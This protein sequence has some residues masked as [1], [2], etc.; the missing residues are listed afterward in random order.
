M[1]VTTY[2]IQNLSTVDPVIVQ[3]IDFDTQSGVQHTAN[4]SGLGGGATTAETRNSSQERQNKTY[5]T[6]SLLR[7]SILAYTHPVSPYYV[8]HTGT[9]LVV[10]STTGIE[11]GWTADDNYYTGT[12][13]VNVLPGNTLLMS[14]GPSNTPSNLR[15]ITFTPTV[16]RITVEDTT[17]VK[18]GWEISGNGYSSGQ[19]VVTVISP[20]QLYVSDQPDTTPALGYGNYISFSTSPYFLKLDSVGRLEVGFSA[21][22]SNNNWDGSQYITDIDPGEKTV[23]MS[24]QPNGYPNTGDTIKFVSNTTLG[25]IQPLQSAT[26][27]MDY[28]RTS[29]GVARYKGSA[30]IFAIQ[31]TSVEKSIGNF[32]DIALA[33]PPPDENPD[34]PYYSPNQ[35]GGRGNGGE[36]APA[37]C[38]TGTPS[39]GD[40]NMCR[41][42]NSSPGGDCFVKGTLVTLYDGSQIAIENLKIGD[43]IKGLNGI[44]AVKKVNI[45]L[46][47]QPGKRDG[48]LWGIN[49]LGK[50]VTAEHPIMT[51]QGW[52]TIDYDHAMI[53]EPHLVDLLIGSIEIGDE[54]LTENGS[55]IIVKSIDVYKDQPQQD[56]YNLLLDGDH[57]YYANGLLVHNKD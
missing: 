17:G 14:S 30:T 56:V 11:A 37:N 42:N 43:Y 55:Y 5:Q 13:V 2:T 29:G 7:S 26:F 24:A 36:S 39:T 4:L 9:T 6:G 15:Q 44:N 21:S 49:D 41:A 31:G 45:P 16:N 34:S 22:S 46:L 52:K 53:L 48:T 54:I 51:K 38:P 18:A 33:P 32:I 25:T 28:S 50:F 19:T 20:T 10:S 1:A 8:S 47:I 57:T 3:Y 40:S 27:T 23:Y 12:Y 35:G